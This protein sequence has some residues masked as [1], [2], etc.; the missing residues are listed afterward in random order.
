MN[1]GTIPLSKPRKGSTQASPV[2]LLTSLNPGV[3]ESYPGSRTTF[4]FFSSV[5][6]N[7][8]SSSAFPSFSWHWHFTKI[9]GQLH[10]QSSLSF[11]LSDVFSQLEWGYTFL[12]RAP[13]KS[14]VWHHRAHVDR[15]SV[16]VTLTSISGDADP[17]ARFLQ[18]TA[19]S[20]PVQSV[21]GDCGFLKMNV[22]LSLRTVCVSPACWWL[23]LP[24]R[25]EASNEDEQQ[26][27]RLWKTPKLSVT[28][29][30]SSSLFIDPL[31]DSSL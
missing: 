29:R 20:F 12:T 2:Y 23:Q 7:L 19:T 11:G 9:T 6:C 30:N 26:S 16:W 21:K 24:G 1:T 5:S 14:R 3:P 8:S 31:E 27:R 4:S 22:W 25:W 28:K 13:Q 10:C 18:C 15:S 17:T